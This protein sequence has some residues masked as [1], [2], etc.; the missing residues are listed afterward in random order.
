M[1]RDGVLSVLD[2][3]RDACKP[4]AAR[5]GGDRRCLRGGSAWVAL[6]AHGPANHPPRVR[7]RHRSNWNPERRPRRYPWPGS[8]TAA[9]PARRSV[10]AANILLTEA[11]EGKLADF[12]V[13]ARLSTT[14]PKR[15]TV[16]GTPMWMSPEMIEAGQYDQLT[17]IWSL[18]ITAIELAQMD[19]PL[20]DVTPA[21]RALLDPRVHALFLPWRRRRSQSPSLV[22]LA[23]PARVSTPW[24]PRRRP[25]VRRFECSS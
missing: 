21:V 6:P 4:A 20:F 12:G 1:D 16:I 19:P 9:P 8:L 22:R 7:R 24:P 11:G 25:R 17:D 5:R 23:P 14:L 2:A 15:N 10:K 13:S 18:G 3:G